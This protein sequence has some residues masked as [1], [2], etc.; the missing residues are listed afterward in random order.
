M[1]RY[2]ISVPCHFGIESVLKREIQDLGYEPSEVM[3][4][5]VVFPGDEEAV[6]RVNIGS[7]T[8]QRVLINVGDFT[9]L[10]FTELH[11]KTRDIPW[12]EY[13]PR[14]GKCWVAK[15]SSVKSALFSPSDIQSVMKAAIA[16]R[17]CEHYH[18]ERL[19]EDGAAY[20]LRVFIHK[21]RVMI[22][23][24]TTGESLH[25]R[26][27][28]KHTPPAP[29]AENLAA[30]LLKLTPWKPGRILVDPFCG[31]G[32]I[33]IEAALMEAN[34]SPGAY[35]EFTAMDWGHLVHAR[36]WEDAVTEAKDEE[37]R[38]VRPQLQGYDIDESVIEMARANAKLAGVEE[39]IHFQ[40]RPVSELAHSGRYGFIVTNP[41]YGER[42]ESEDTLP[43]IYRELGERFRNL[44]DWSLYFITSFEKAQEAVGRRA[45]KNR[46]IY[47]GMVKTY[48]YQYPG[49]KPPARKQ[50]NANVK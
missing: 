48:F 45:P 46:K 40:K 12:E 33:P 23:L 9:A 25:K 50:E 11:D 38:S 6:A 5:R 19:P 2:T 3:D 14:N 27:Y 8:G 16:K 42:M 20:P 32:T 34:I 7:R 17:L 35:R 47:N 18:L 13:I 43:G 44:K 15:A 31:S 4:G 28:R 26:G 10:T 29:I 30:A 24:D 21:D 22:G 36:Y 37:D 39:L 41:P 1:N 49:A